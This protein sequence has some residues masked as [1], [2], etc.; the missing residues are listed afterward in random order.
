[1]IKNNQFFIKKI[2]SVVIL[3]YSNKFEELIKI[4][5][6]LNLKVFIITSKDQ[7]KK[8]K[9]NKSKIH[10][11]NNIDSKFKNFILKSMNVNET[12]F[13]S[14]FAR[15]IFKEDTIKNFF[16][17]NLINFHDSR[18]PKDAGGGGYSWRIMKEDRINSQVSHLIDKGID[19]GPIIDY[20]FS[21]F[22][23]NCQTPIELENFADSEFLKF[24]KKILFKI[25]KGNHFD[26]TYQVRYLGTYNPRLDTETNGLIDWNSDSYDLINFINAFDEPYK[27]AST[28]INNKNLGKLYLK[29][30]QLHGGESLNHPYMAGLVLRHDIDW[31]VVSTKSKHTLLIEKVLDVNGKNQLDKIKAGDRFLVS[32]EKLYK[33]KIDRVRYGSKGKK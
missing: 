12:L 29:K 5:T 11:F 4:V 1:M 31:I 28:Y 13:V 32:Q 21:L 10:I 25:K 17:G 20:N 27:G 2:T 15:Y 23:K 26:L 16:K 24:F 19:S 14:R 3:G 18:L 30:V 22:P 9:K 6:D 7:A 33:S 8:I